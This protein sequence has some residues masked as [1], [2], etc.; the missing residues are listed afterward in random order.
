MKVRA[1]ELLDYLDEQSLVPDDTSVE[2]DF[3]DPTTKVAFIEGEREPDNYRA[4][5]GAKAPIM[6]AI[7]QCKRGE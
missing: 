5:N 2:R 6:G 4:I 7:K 3:D 1:Q